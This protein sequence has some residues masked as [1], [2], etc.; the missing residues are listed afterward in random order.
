MA[1]ITELDPRSATDE[2]FQQVHEV[3]AACHAEI[4]RREPYRTAAETRAY[5]RHPPKSDER[6]QWIGLLN[7]VAVGVAQLSSLRGSQA[8]HLQIHVRSDARRLGIAHS[9]L[10]AAI[11]HAHDAHLGSLIGH[12]A[13]LAGSRF[14]ARAGFI[15]GRRNVR[16][17]IALGEA[18]LASD[19]VPGYA[20]QSWEGPAPSELL[21]SYA[22]VREAINDEPGATDDDWEP[23]DA[24]R[25]RHLEAA[26]ARR[27]R[28]IRVTAALNAA[29]DVVAFTEL[30]VGEAAGS[31]ASIEDTAVLPAHRRR[32][33]GRWVKTES[34]TSL[35]RA[36]PDVSLVATTNTE[37]NAAIR[38]LN[39]A[40]GFAVE[41]VSTTCVLSLSR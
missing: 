38:D 36:R 41:S 30:R 2:R 17:A 35:R 22:V 40:L 28:Q 3:L 24:A 6:W 13:T 27:G 1:V 4:A 15:D 14:A 11:A 29:S 20:L 7:G 26:A 8:G 34:L 23:F 10:E 19:P 21:E 5:V 32:G 31:V 37:Q 18:R 39:T 33:L 16:S 12:H 25:V 9:L